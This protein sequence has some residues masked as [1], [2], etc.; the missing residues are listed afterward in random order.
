MSH[1]EEN[2]MI[3]KAIL[4]IDN[5]KGVKKGGSSGNRF[6]RQDSVLTA[7]ADQLRQGAPDAAS[8]A[9]GTD[10]VPG[11]ASAS[12][13]RISDGVIAV[14]YNPASIRYHASTS[15]QKTAEPDVGTSTEMVTTIT[16]KSTVD[17]SFQLVFHSAG[18]T[19]ESVREQM[20]L[21]MNMLYDSPTKK[22]SFAW[23]K[24]EMEGKLVGF[25]GEY[26]MF[27]A[28]GRPVS[29][30]MQLTL[31]METMVKQVERTL[32]RLDEEHKNKLAEHDIKG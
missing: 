31:R 26:D 6:Q 19:D 13:G 10:T 14:Q 25:S 24:I 20:E 4:R 7:A 11:K 22:V 29:G 5:S 9:Q 15:E 21:V 28:M 8:R 2:D 23:G 16:G 17:M 27:D 18:E 30:H 3:Q 1:D 32:N 12:S